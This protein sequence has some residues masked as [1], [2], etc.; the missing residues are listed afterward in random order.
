MFFLAPVEETLY[1]RDCGCIPVHIAD[2]TSLAYN[3]IRIFVPVILIVVGM[4]TLASSLMSQKDDEIKKAQSKLIQK[5]IAAV[6]VF[7]VFTL[8]QFAFNIVSN[9]VTDTQKDN[10]WKC[11]DYMLNHDENT[12]MITTKT[13]N[14]VNKSN[15]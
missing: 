8:V 12:Q 6:A 2:L 1:L 13:C 3:S 10:I 5:V 9:T 14:V 7:L 15:P 11:I 4:I